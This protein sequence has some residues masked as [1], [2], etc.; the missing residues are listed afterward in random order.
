MKKKI[1]II[2]GI[3]IAIALAAVLLFVFFGNNERTLEEITLRKHGGGRLR[4]EVDQYTTI[5]V[6][7]VSSSKNG[8]ERE[9]ICYVSTNH[10]KKASYSA[11]GK[12]FDY[13]DTKEYPCTF[14][15]Y[16]LTINGI[17]HYT[18]H[19]ETR[20]DKEYVVFSKPF[21]GLTTWYIDK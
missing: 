10:Y 11:S 14:T 8:D 6:Y 15:D 2:I 4:Y 3:V 20:S 7:F 17:D 9:G 12:I 1:V 18:Y 5:E 21:L 16:S 19:T 13:A